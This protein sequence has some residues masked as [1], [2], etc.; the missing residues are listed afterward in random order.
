MNEK[1]T[2]NKTMTNELCPCGSKKEYANCCQPYI[3]GTKDAPT[4]EALMRSRYSAYV[5]EAFQYVYDSYHSKTKQH[6]TLDAIK[7]QSSKI[8]WLGLTVSGTKNGTVND[9]TGTVSF[10]AR[11]EMDGKTQNLIEKSFFAKEKGRWYY[12]NGETQFTT[13]AKSTKVGRNDPC[14]CGSGKKFKKCCG[15]I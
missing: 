13:T 4:A 11:Y 1:L 3:E 8:T 2:K 10:T 5:K 15:K 14:T 6:F 7:E 9:K 12:I